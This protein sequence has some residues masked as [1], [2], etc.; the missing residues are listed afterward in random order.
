[1]SVSFR[2]VTALGVL[3]LLCG[4]PSKKPQEP[5]LDG[6]AFP[7]VYVTPPVEGADP[8]VLQQVEAMGDSV[9]LLSANVVVSFDRRRTWKEINA[10]ALGSIHK[11]VFVTPTSGI[12][13][14]G[15]HGL[16]Y[17]QLDTDIIYYLN[18]EPGWS[19]WGLR[20]GD[21]LFTVRQQVDAGTSQRGDETARVWLGR[22][23]RFTEDAPW[24]EVEL[25]PLPFSYRTYQP[26]VH[27]TANGDIYVASYFGLQV[28]RDDGQTWQQVPVMPNEQGSIDWR[29]VD[30]FVTR[31]GTLFARTPNMTFVSHD[32]GASWVGAAMPGGIGNRGSMMTMEEPVPGELHFRDVAYRSTDEGRSYQQVFTLERYATDK[33]LETLFYRGG[34]Y[35]FNLALLSNFVSAAPDTS[36]G[37]LN[38]PTV[39]NLT[40]GNLIRAFP[41][42]P[43]RY[44]GL[45]NQGF[46]TYT[47]GDT[48]WKV[49]RFFPNT[50]FLDKLRDGRLALARTGGLS[51]SRDEGVTW[52]EPGP[53]LGTSPLSVTVKSLVEI[54]G[55]LFLSGRDN[56]DC[57]KLALLESLDG[58]ASWRAVNAASILDAQQA[59]VSTDTHHPELTTADRNG[60]LL[61]RV[62]ELFG[63]RVQKSFTA[64]SED[65]GRTWKGTSERVPL[66][67]TSFSNLLAVED[68][69]NTEEIMY[70]DR[71]QGRWQ[72]YGPPQVE[73]TTVRELF[74]NGAPFLH[75]DGADFVYFTDNH[76]VLRSDQPV[77]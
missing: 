28:S 41:M 49:E 34:E 62:S 19:A 12:A 60:Q 26:S 71:A 35:Y 5:Q 40:P 30:L 63:C 7:L 59:P 47:H 31:A 66:A 14:T 38:P 39:A 65:L 57:N 32:G 3:A 52:S 55:R 11:W 22:R 56:G 72:S 70:W 42:S 8:R 13:H 67:S 21:T 10:G 6:S 23:Q 73:G 44:A 33:S 36:L 77:H 51:F 76:R 29:G 18:G 74:V 61:G 53:L 69:G 16:A 54:P 50:Y 20:N 15:Q 58:G 24:P 17:I 43:G 46:I 37:I 4:C 45:W 64:S 9:Y 48:E 1:M 68:S 75:V 2:L 27:F 25:P